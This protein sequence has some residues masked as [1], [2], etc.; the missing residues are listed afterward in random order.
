MKNLTDT[1]LRWRLEW[2]RYRQGGEL[3]MSDW[4]TLYG[5]RGQL[6]TVNGDQHA[7]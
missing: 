1:L 4:K 2:K 5:L 3:T 7:N 6:T